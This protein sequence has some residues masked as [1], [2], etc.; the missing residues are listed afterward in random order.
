[1]FVL[2]A[3]QSFWFNASKFEFEA[4]KKNSIFYENDGLFSAFCILHKIHMNWK[5]LKRCASG[6]GSKGKS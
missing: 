4:V 1:M 6:R 5:D 2:V 3:L